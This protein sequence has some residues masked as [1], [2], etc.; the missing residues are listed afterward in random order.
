[1]T[2]KYSKR[3]ITNRGKGEKRSGDVHPNAMPEKGQA[4]LDE[5]EHKGEVDERVFPCCWFPEEID[6]VKHK[7]KAK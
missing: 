5:A 6:G 3:T 7:E 1:M 4:E 2:K